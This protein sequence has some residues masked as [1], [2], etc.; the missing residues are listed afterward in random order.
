MCA[1]STWSSIPSASS[2]SIWVVQHVETSVEIGFPSNWPLISMSHQENVP[3]AHTNGLGCSNS[4]G[5]LDSAAQASTGWGKSPPGGSQLRWNFAR[6]TSEFTLLIVISLPLP[7]PVRC[8]DPHA[9]RH[10]IARAQERET[11]RTV[12]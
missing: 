12:I 11:A 9:V 3:P 10:V 7:P 6:P 2:I 8:V 5:F 1:L 4:S